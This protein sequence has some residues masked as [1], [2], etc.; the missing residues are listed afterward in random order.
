MPLPQPPNNPAVDAYIGLGSNLG[1]RAGHLLG[2]LADLAASA[3]VAV[4]AASTLLETEPWAPPGVPDSAKGDHYLN[5]AAHLR[6]ALP[7]AELL[8][9][10]LDIERRHG[11]DRAATGRWGPRTLDL[12]LLV[13]GDRIVHEPGLTLPHPR[14]HERRFVLEPLAQIAP[15]LTIPTLGKTT[16]ELLR[17]LGRPVAH[18]A[19]P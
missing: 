2:A 1:D 14:L 19:K 6:T 16:A 10:L 18:G 9:L 11:R 13:Y 5:A 4:A 12:D 3:G 8:R 7:P 17:V 15:L